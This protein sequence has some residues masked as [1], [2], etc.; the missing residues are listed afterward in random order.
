MHSDRKCCRRRSA[1]GL[2]CCSKPVSSDSS[3]NAV[4]CVPGRSRSDSRKVVQ[5]AICYKQPCQAQRVS[6]SLAK[7]ASL[8][9]PHRW[10]APAPCTPLAPLLYA[11]YVG[12]LRADISERE[13]EDRECPQAA[14]LSVAPPCQ[15]QNHNAAHLPCAHFAC[16]VCALWPPLQG[17]WLR[18]MGVG[19]A[20]ACTCTA[21]ELRIMCPCSLQ[22]G[23]GRQEATRLCVSAAHD[24]AGVA[25]AVLNL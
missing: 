21:A 1:G 4:R 11:V 17:A 24:A 18:G 15:H 5:P 8:H 10:E 2:P 12:G 16:R 20:H 23:L 25:C 13:V 19:L 14:R 9:G 3:V 22:T 7:H 6:F